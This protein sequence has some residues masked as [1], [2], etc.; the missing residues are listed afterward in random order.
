MSSSP[1][2]GD[3]QKNPLGRPWMR[4]AAKL[5]KRQLI[6]RQKQM[7]RRSLPGAVPQ[8]TET[9]YYRGAVARWAGKSRGPGQV[10]EALRERQ[11]QKDLGCL[12]GRG[13][14]SSDFERSS[15]VQFGA[16]CGCLEEPQSFAHGRAGRKHFAQVALLKP[17][18]R[19][20]K[21]LCLCDG[22]PF[23]AREENNFQIYNLSSLKLSMF[24]KALQ[25]IITKPSPATTVQFAA[26]CC[27][28]LR[29]SAAKS[30]AEY[31]ESQLRFGALLAQATPSRCSG[32]HMNWCGQQALVI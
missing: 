21:G 15:K 16:Y 9:R 17:D 30:W 7:S 10:G 14:Q 32:T 6:G 18:G 23:E 25:L 8:R 19:E 3:A 1:A 5:L 29:P 12:G 22:R 28:E 4:F 26:R 13:I 31:N 11:L 20:K 2:S 24:C 27:V